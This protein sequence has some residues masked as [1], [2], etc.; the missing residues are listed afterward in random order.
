MMDHVNNVLSDIE[1]VCPA[2][3]EE[4]GYES[5][6]AYYGGIGYGGDERPDL[7][8]IYMALEGLRA[9][10]TDP[11]DPAWDKALAFVSRSQ[12]RSESNDQ[13]WANYEAIQADIFDHLLS[14]VNHF[15]LRIFQDP[16]GQDLRSLSPSQA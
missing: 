4:E 12:N 1:R 16:S 3:D 7:S 2:Y 15:G 6:H 13:A 10:A 14:A 9:T 5:D 8:N 11:E